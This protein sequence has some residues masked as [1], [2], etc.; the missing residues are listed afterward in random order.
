MCAIPQNDYYDYSPAQQHRTWAH[1]I[2][3]FCIF[4]VYNLSLAVGIVKKKEIMHFQD[5]TDV[6]TPKNK[7]P[8]PRGP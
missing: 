5:M 8:L 6:L 3:N 1:E 7:N 2:Y 4:G